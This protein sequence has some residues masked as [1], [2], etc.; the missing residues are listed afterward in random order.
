MNIKLKLALI[1]SGRSQF[2]VAQQLGIS[3]TRLSR[4]VRGRLPPSDDEAKRIAR[5]LR[6]SPTQLFP[7]LDKPRT[8]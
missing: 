6:V 5:I 1:Q 3:E 4:L 2:E 8:E 7:D